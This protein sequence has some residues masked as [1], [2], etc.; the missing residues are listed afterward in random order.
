MEVAESRI[1]ELRAI[2]NLVSVKLQD[3][4]GNEATWDVVNSAF[5]M[6]RTL[7]VEYTAS[8]FSLSSKHRGSVSDV[9]TCITLLSRAPQGMDLTHLIPRG[10]TWRV[11]PPPSSRNSCLWIISDDLE[12]STSPLSKSTDPPTPPT[13]PTPPPPSQHPQNI[14]TNLSLRELITLECAPTKLFTFFSQLVQVHWKDLISPLSRLD[15]QI[16]QK[17]NWNPLMG[18]FTAF[19]TW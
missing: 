11:Q 8:I 5:H 3:E 9:R 6:V 15:S 18:E 10:S 2:S 14:L 13:P 4:L 17:M 16:V 12:T 1:W 19:E 7:F